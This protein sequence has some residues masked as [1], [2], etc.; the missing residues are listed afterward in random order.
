MA[1]LHEQIDT[2]RVLVVDQALVFNEFSSGTPDV[3]AY[4]K[5][6]KMSYDRG[7]SSDGHKLGYTL[8]FG[9]PLYDNRGITSVAQSLDYPRML[10]WQSDDGANE[11]SSFCS[12]DILACLSDG[13]NT[14]N[15]SLRGMDIAIARMPVKNIRPATWLTSLSSMLPSGISGR[16]KTT[17]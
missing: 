2:M 12:D 15:V 10:M 7:T 5:L 1:S 8:L 3:M 9:R 14:D 4:R 11:N 16:G 13:S 6:A 17:L